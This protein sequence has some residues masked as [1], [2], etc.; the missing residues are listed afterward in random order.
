[1]VLDGII[2]TVETRNT[3]YSDG[4]F[5]GVMTVR[6]WGDI[7]APR[8]C[9]ES[10]NFQEVEALNQLMDLRSIAGEELIE[11]CLLRTCAKCLRVKPFRQL[12]MC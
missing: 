4:D 8:N 1:M 2:P 6:K 9:I 3:G 11:I 7:L 12:L 10:M 5:Y